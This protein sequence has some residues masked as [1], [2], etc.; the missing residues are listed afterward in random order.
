MQKIYGVPPEKIDFIP[1][2]IPDVPFVDP[3]FHKDLFG[4]EGKTVLLSFGLLSANKGI[5]TVIAAL[6]AILA[7]HPN[8]VYII[9]GATHPH[10][11]RNEGE[12]YRLS[13]QWLAQEKGVEGHVIF[14]NRFVSLEELVEFIGAADIYITPYL[15]EA[16]DH[17]RHPGLYAGG[18]QSRDFDPLLV[19]GR[20][21]G[22]RTGRAGPV[23]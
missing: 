7:R 3:S 22:R 16:A 5:E 21:A 10:V 8:V 23:P 1:H 4:V 9:L 13:L 17:L 20:D 12:T 15:N 11:M 6:P 2:G 18:G 19:C 14:Y